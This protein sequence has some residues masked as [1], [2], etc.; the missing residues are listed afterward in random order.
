MDIISAHK[1]SVH[2]RDALKKANRC[3]CFFCLEI[4]SPKE[5]YDWISFDDT[6]ICP[7]CWVDSVIPESSELSLTE[8]FLKEMHDYWFRRITVDEKLYALQEI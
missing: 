6:A 8:A 4:Y 7:H 5:I 2:N 3:G 1:L